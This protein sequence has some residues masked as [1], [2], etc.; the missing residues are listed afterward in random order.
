MSTAPLRYFG[1]LDDFGGKEHY[2]TVHS[3][4]IFSPGYKECSMFHVLQ[5]NMYKNEKD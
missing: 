5:C 2:T 1:L 3:R 4:P